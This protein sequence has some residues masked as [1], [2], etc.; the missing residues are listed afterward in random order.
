MPQQRAEA[1][2]TLSIT[3]PLPHHHRHHLISII[4]IVV[5]VVL[6]E[7]IERTA[8]T[9]L[10]CVWRQ[11]CVWKDDVAGAAQRCCGVCRAEACAALCS[12]SRS[13]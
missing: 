6:E 11:H 9:L 4:I 13:R 10:V 7:E 2:T 5:V 1:V 8:N 3:Q 12:A